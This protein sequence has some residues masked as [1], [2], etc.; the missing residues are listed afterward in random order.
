MDQEEAASQ[1]NDGS[2]QDVEDGGH[3]TI[4]SMDRNEGKDGNDADEEEDA[5]Q[6]DDGSTQNVRDRGIE[7]E[8]VKIRQYIS[9][10]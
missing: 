9:D 3:S 2:T 5:S 7:L 8:S 4:S 10:Q 1:G 6:A